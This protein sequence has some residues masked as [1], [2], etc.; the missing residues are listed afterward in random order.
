MSIIGTETLYNLRHNYDF[1][2]FIFYYNITDIKLK[3]CMG[4]NNE[5]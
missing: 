2:K 4:D 1:S 5:Y 3:F